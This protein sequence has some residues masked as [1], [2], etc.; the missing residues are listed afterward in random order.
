MNRS[1]NKITGPNAGG[2]RQFAIPTSLAARVGQF[3]RSA[4]MM[5]ITALV[6]AVLV[7]SLTGCERESGL[8]G[9]SPPK[10]DTTISREIATPSGDWAGRIDY[11]Y[12]VDG[13]PRRASYEFTTFNGY[14]ATTEDFATTKCV[15]EYN[16]SGNGSLVLDSKVTT[17]LSSG[18]RVERTFYEPE[19]T[20]WV[21]LAE[22]RKELQAEQAAS[23][24]H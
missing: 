23:S 8:A 18:E 21:T 12:G 22:A 15:R 3:W 13:L 19:I 11:T 20:H 6:L 5:K 1:P 17:D 4:I 7:L 2:P 10:G 24:N 14:D 16:A 9:G